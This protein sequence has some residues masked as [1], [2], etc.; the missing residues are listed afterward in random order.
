M[1]E[2]Y[3]KRIEALRPWRYN[4]VH[5]NIEIKADNQDVAVAHDKYYKNAL[6]R[7]LEIICK[8][9]PPVNELR[10][11]DLGCLEGHYSDILCSYGF[12]EV[13]SVDLSENHIKRAEFLLH[14]L[15]QYKNSKVIQGNVLSDSLL[16]SLGKFDIIFFHGLLYHLSS[17]VMIFDN[18][19]KIINNKASFFMLLSHQFHMDYKIMVSPYPVSELRIR[20]FK[21]DEK[22]LVFS[23]KDES[24]FDIASIRLNPV[25]L[26]DLLHAYK[27]EEVIS[28]DTPTGA[29]LKGKNF[30]VN[31]VL[32]KRKIEGL[33]ESLNSGS[34]RNNFQFTNWDGT[35][36]DNYVF[37]KQLKA[38]MI[39]C[40][41]KL[42][43]KALVLFNKILT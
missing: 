16:L 1:S 31:F 29:K 32:S 33:L 2:D 43:D 19:E 34:L 11:L 7:I 14:T 36:L 27:Y 5:G 12:K 23:P 35:S 24:V 10:V 26:K 15:K 30:A 6:N 39:R 21:A 28:Y 8:H 40:F 13:V 38:I 18:I 37:S 22:G 20:R 3:Q 17:P 9:L 25:C 42:T 4:H 41:I